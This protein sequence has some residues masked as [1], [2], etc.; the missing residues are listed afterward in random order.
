MIG[1]H[2]HGVELGAWFDGEG[3]ERVG[4]HLT[5]CRRC[6]RRADELAAVRAWL[7]GSPW[8]AMRSESVPSPAVP[9]PVPWRRTAAAA[10]LLVLFALLVPVDGRQRV[11]SDGPSWLAH[12][13]VL[14]PSPPEA[15]AVEVPVET[16][17]VLPPR[18]AVETAGG[19]PVGQLE[20]R[21]TAPGRASGPAPA[22]SP[23][24]SSLLRLGLV[25]PT[26]G[27]RAAEGVEVRD[28]VSAAVSAAN[29][30]GGVNGRPVELVVAA[31]EDPS[32][33]AALR[34]RGVTALV[35]GFGVQAPLDLPWLLPADPSV[36]GPSVLAAEPSPETA[37]VQLATVLRR[38][39]LDG[40]IGVVVGSGPEAAFASGLASRAATLPMVTAPG[41]SC[42]REIAALHRAG[43]VALAVAA[44]PDLAGRCLQAARRLGWSPR[45]GTLVTPS[46]AYA[47]LDVLSDASGTRTV[48][49]FPWPT[50]KAPGAARFRSTNQSVSYRALVSF[51]AAEL[52]IAVAR[53]AG[54]V[55]L[56]ALSDGTWRTDLVNFVGTTSRSDTVVTASPSAWLPTR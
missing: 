31:A 17:D 43:A 4:A 33:I 35:G 45:F 42:D 8:V 3:S 25:V 51:A 28:A 22:I 46:A 55:S 50:S 36:A 40:S 37:G 6:Q 7:R 16:E 20:Q 5:G 2:P 32:A 47:R 38:L 34:R 54:A 52:A 24:S 30:G 41:A 15:P 13:P 14:E 21:G 19:P 18:Q 44:D 9:A 23:G 11:G 29:A 49:A 56:A 27:L 12:A 39:G 53:D 26:A 10:A 1:R 48:L